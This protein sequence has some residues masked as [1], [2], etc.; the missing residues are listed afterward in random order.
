MDEDEDAA[1]GYGQY[2]PISRAVEVIGERWSFLVLRDLLVGA[3]RF[4]E[5]AR[6]E[7]GLS[8]TLLSKRL[9]QF[10][11]AGLVVH[12]GDRYLLTPAG[13]DLRPVI[14]SLGEWGARWAFGEP[15]PAELDAQLLVW[16]MHTRIDRA[17]LP[18][19]RTV[20]E[21]CFSDDPRHFWVVAD[22]GGPSVCLNDP[23]FEVDVLIRS[24]VRSLYEVWMGTLPLAAALRSGRVDLQGPRELVARM[25]RVLQLSPVAGMVAAARTA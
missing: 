21:L 25:D 18:A 8:R 17:A 16:W 19:P 1:T 3:T 5:I 15:R 13:E 14:F 11:R 12:E 6:L 23:G 9:R 24:D 20:F 2:C 7:P 22:D 10:E 4:N